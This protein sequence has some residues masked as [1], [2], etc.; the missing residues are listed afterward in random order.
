MPLFYPQKKI[1]VTPDFGRSDSWHSSFATKYYY[2]EKIKN[3]EIPLWTNL[4]GGGHPFAA[5]GLASPF[6]PPNILLFYFFN[7]VTAYN[8]HLLFL[9]YLTGLGMYVWLRQFSL[10]VVPS[11]F[12]ALTLSLSGLVM[13]QLTHSLLL[14]GFSFLPLILGLTVQLSRVKSVTSAIALSIISA[15]QILTGYPQAVL[16]TYV[17]VIILYVWL[18]W[19]QPNKLY[20]AVRMVLVFILT[21]GLSAIQL[22]PSYE[23]IQQSIVEGGFSPQLAMYFS[24]PLSHIKTLLDPFAL[25]NPKFGTYP[26]F[27]A[28]D[29]SV[30]W[31]NSGYIGLLPLFFVFILFIQK[32]KKT[33][34]GNGLLHVSIFMLIAS[35]LLMLGKHSPL[36]FIY[37]F[38][39]FT[40][41][42][43]PS[44]FLWTFI[45]A[46]VSLASLGF[47]GLWNHSSTKTK[48][49]LLIL[50]ILNAYTLFTVWQPYHALVPAAPWLKKP[51]IIPYLSDTT[52]MITIGDT[53]TYNKIF[54]TK[55]W[56]ST[57]QYEFLRNSMTPDSNLIWQIPQAD[58]YAGRSLRR[59]AIF[60]ALLTQNI[61]ISEN[62]ATISATALKLLS[63][64]SVDTILTTIPLDPTELPIIGSVENNDTRITVFRNPKPLPRV[65]FASKVHIANT[66]ESASA[67]LV[68]DDFVLGES[69][70]LEDPVS[71]PP[72]HNNA[73]ASI[74][75][76]RDRQIKIQTTGVDHES[77]LV[78]T[79]TYYPGW[80]ASV[81]GVISKIY[82]ANIRHRAVVIPPGTNDV[83]FTYA[84]RSFLYGNWVTIGT[85]GIIGI[86]VVVQTLS[87]ASRTHQIVDSHDLRRRHSHDT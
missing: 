46:L 33:I 20:I 40:L 85:F 69:V 70:L 29:G 72:I 74:V 25:G 64:N 8:L 48:A 78:L 66:A 31:E 2:A 49:I 55:G 16:I 63:L 23:L 42:R 62:L 26:F 21:F 75:D 58:V 65:Y 4:L 37:S 73:L 15:L 39:P 27:A 68:R 14:S 6:F 53:V 19:S 28:F 43:V 45:I 67:V 9:V 54:N 17:C 60:D 71:I 36:Y 80:V 5:D 56:Q 76:Y 87:S 44:R 83:T 84:P 38:W 18:N 35:F 82:P 10:S 24:Y 3:G 86:I 13:T 59:N 61:F 57:Q 79:D 51:E 77:I 1:L 50:I 47:S 81:D 41:F 30:F 32:N 52:R 7:S 11:L 12:G 34:I 22:F